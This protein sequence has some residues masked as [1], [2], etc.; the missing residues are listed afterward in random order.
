[1]IFT[2]K[3]GPRGRSLAR[4]SVS[5]R[6][7]PPEP[8]AA[9][10]IYLKFVRVFWSAWRAVAHDILA[11]IEN[12]RADAG[13][14]EALG[15]A[16]DNL[17]GSTNFNRWIDRA[18]RGVDDVRRSYY[19]SIVGVPV[20]PPA[21]QDEIVRDWRE[22]NARLIKGLRG[23]HID[24]LIST[25]DDAAAQG[26]RHEDLARVLNERFDVGASRAKLIARDQ[27]LKFN[28]SVNEAQQRSLGV[29]E[30]TWS[31]SKDSHVRES[32]RKLDGQRF[33]WDRPPIVD[34]V[35]STPG[36]PIQ[37]RCRAIPVVQLFEGI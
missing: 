18:A 35:P 13:E 36:Q 29:E 10:A 24:D 22:E 6:H 31:T 8:R 4:G 3:A 21:Q 11:P 12:A 37:C 33:R 7:A 1:M 14:R 27:T 9:I 28:A 5:A 17:L 23:E 25:L 26:M 20:P 30:F 34:G 16:W 15:A 2:R 32:H 19:K